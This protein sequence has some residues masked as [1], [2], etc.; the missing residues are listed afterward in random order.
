MED[1]LEVCAF[2]GDVTNPASRPLE[3]AEFYSEEGRKDEDDQ[4]GMGS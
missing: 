2:G 3:G 1:V 4:F